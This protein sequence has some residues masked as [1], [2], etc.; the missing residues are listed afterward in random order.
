MICSICGHETASGQFCEKCGAKLVQETENPNGTSSNDTEQAE[1]VYYHSAHPAGGGQSVPADPG[2]ARQEAAA[3]HQHT[4]QSPNQAPYQDPHQA[5][6]PQAHVSG[7]SGSA[8]DKLKPYVD[9]ARESSKL[10]FDFFAKSL[11]N[12]VGVAQRIGANQMV[13]GI[14]S[15]VLFALLLPLVI[16]I[17]AVQSA[18]R[19][20]LPFFDIVIKP[21]FW[22]VLVLLLISVY[23]FGAVKLSTKSSVDLREVI[24]RFGALLVPFIVLVLIGFVFILM[25][26]RLGAAFYS[27]AMIG[28][29]FTVPAVIIMSYKKDSLRGVDP[30][31]GIL[32]VYAAVMITMMLIGDSVANIMQPSSMFRF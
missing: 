16:Y 18:F 19:R 27:L 9:T 14:I 22:I 13:N 32:L 1:T 7:Q 25:E 23:I 26:S 31:Y 11:K 10:Y 30:L 3:D 15:I 4:Y 12:P 8:G 24:A 5:S 29:I 17:I 6:G 28:A 20:D 21:M 2:M